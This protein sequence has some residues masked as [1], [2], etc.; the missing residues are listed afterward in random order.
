MI[1][2]VL[3]CAQRADIGEVFVATDS[4]EIGDVVRRAGG[5]VVMTRSDHVSGSDRVC[6]A[7]EL[8]D[9]Q[10][11]SRFVVNLQGDVPTL[12]PAHLGAVL[13][14]LDDDEVD[15]ATLA[16]EM[17]TDYE[18]ES[19]S[20]VKVIGRKVTPNR[21]EARHFTRSLASPIRDSQESSAENEISLISGSIYAFTRPKFLH[22]IGVYAYKRAALRRFVELPPSQGEL[23]ENLEQLRAL[24]NGMRIDVTI[25]DSVPLG[26][27]TPEDLARVREELN[28]GPRPGKN[29]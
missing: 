12:P 3:R 19:T 5:R 21:I 10:G 7:L 16:A 29:A 23:R 28:S 24:D 18:W 14:P 1:E 22:H 20:V 17:K 2:R 25:V 4:H 9:P 26:V 8:V 6:E 15:V 27:D 11:K 13:A